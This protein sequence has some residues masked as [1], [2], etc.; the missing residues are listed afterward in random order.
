MKIIRPLLLLLI[1]PCFLMLLSFLPKS[2]GA[3]ESP[4]G[5]ALADHSAS[6]FDAA[7]LKAR[8]LNYDAFSLALKG[9]EKLE[10]EGKIEKTNLITIADFSQSSCRKRLY[11]IDLVQQKILFQTFV[12]H[13]KNSG[14]E[15][16]Q[17]FSNEPQSNKSSLGFYTTLETYYGEHGLS[18]RLK[19]EEAG[20]NNN[21][22]DRAIV[23]HGAGYVSQQ[24]VSQNGRLG[25]SQGCPALPAEQCS[26]IINEL[27]NGSCIFLYYPD[28]NYLSESL[29]LQD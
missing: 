6:L 23:M 16:A 1:V 14:E 19:G 10:A 20:I 22:F 15:Y 9:K 11:V 28:K 13:G 18:L 29:L 26:A 17:Y 5:I 2:T 7:G 4:A 3:E 24:F 25:R 8:G 27:K 12:A 21:A